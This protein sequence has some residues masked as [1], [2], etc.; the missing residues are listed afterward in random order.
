MRL[1]FAIIAILSFT[2]L[3]QAETRYIV[4]QAKLPMRSGEGTGFKIIKM[5]PSGM[6]VEVL[7]QSQ[8]GYSRVRARDGKEGWIL[9]RYLMKTPAARDRLQAFEKELSQLSHLKQKNAAADK[10]NRRL[11]AENENLKKEIQHIRKTAANAVEV[12]EQNLALKEE[13]AAAKQ[14]LFDLEQQTVD[15]R[16]GAQQRWFLMGGGA[17]VAGV[18]LGLLLPYMGARRKR[19]WGGY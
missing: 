5:L 14:A 8:T 10:E 4:D 16:S 9:S 3:A 7:E 12:A 6:A 18:I 15:I 1:L 17:I 19:R 11:Q 13:A 2:C